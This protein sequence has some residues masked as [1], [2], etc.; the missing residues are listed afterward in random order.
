MKRATEKA[1]EASKGWS[2]EMELDSAG[3]SAEDARVA[4][5]IRA[6]VEAEAKR[7]METGDFSSGPG[8]IKV[9]FP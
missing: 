4:A 9:C 6:R 7:K 2:S 8:G 5:D 1:Q 3:L